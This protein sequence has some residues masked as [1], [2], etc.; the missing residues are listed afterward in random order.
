[1]FLEMV[2]LQWL[3]RVKCEECMNCLD[4]VLCLLFG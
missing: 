2:A 3:A 4:E 1:M